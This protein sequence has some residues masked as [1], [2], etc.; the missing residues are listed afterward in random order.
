[1]FGGQLLKQ[2]CCYEPGHQDLKFALTQYPRLLAGQAIPWLPTVRE[3]AAAHHSCLAETLLC[4]LQAPRA[5]SSA[6]KS[7]PTPGCLRQP[8]Q[9]C[10]YSLMQTA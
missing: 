9:A 3:S 10:S 4:G 6:S 5:V 8:W 1:M 2:G 7:S